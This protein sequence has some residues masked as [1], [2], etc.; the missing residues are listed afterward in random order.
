MPSPT[1]FLISNGIVFVIGHLGK[2]CACTVVDHV[3]QSLPLPMCIFL[4]SGC[5]KKAN[6][7]YDHIPIGFQASQCAELMILAR[8][9][10]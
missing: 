8:G 4:N 9:V 1:D 6:C 10:L 2:M 5:Y 3:V 7:L